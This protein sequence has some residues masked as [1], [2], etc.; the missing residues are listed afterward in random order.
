MREEFYAGLE[1]RKYLG[2]A[3]A[4]QRAA[5]VRAAGQLRPRAC[6]CAAPA[7]ARCRWGQPPCRESQA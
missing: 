5:Q 7:A 1:D 4:R 2:L 6:L 3:E